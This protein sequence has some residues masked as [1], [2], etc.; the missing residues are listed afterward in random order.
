MADIVSQDFVNKYSIQYDAT[1]NATGIGEK[2]FGA[3]AATIAALG[4]N[5]FNSLVSIPE[6]IPFVGIHGIGVSN[7]S[8]IDMS[9]S[10]IDTY[11][12]LAGINDNWAN[13]YADNKD[14]V[15]TAA[16]I[17]GIIIPAGIALKGM[18]LLQ[19]GRL[20][21][22]A[23]AGL[24]DYSQLKRTSQYWEALQ[25][26]PKNKLLQD[27][28]RRKM[29]FVNVG[30]EA[31]L[32][33][34][35]EV[36]IL[37]TQNQSILMEDY[38]RDPGK[39]ILLG[40][41]G[42]GGAFGA[43]LATV[44]IALGQIAIRS[45]LA[46]GA[47]EIVERAIDD[48]RKLA[49]ATLP[50][51][52]S[53]ID[54]YQRM[55][56][57]ASEL[58][59]YA[60]NDDNI[61][62]HKELAASLA[63]VIEGKA[64]KLL[65]DNIHSPELKNWLDANRT[66]P[67]GIETMKVINGLINFSGTWGGNTI[68]RPTFDLKTLN[69]ATAK[70]FNSAVTIQERVDAATS[71]GFADEVLNAVGQKLGVR[72]IYMGLSTKPAYIASLTGGKINWHHIQ[73]PNISDQAYRV[74]YG[75]STNSVLA[76]ELGH[77][78]AQANNLNSE[79]TLQT[80]LALRKELE[81]LSKSFKPKI[82]DRGPLYAG[83]GRE[84]IADGVAIWMLVPSVRKKMPLFAAH[85]GE[86]VAYAQFDTLASNITRELRKLAMD[87]TSLAISKV[88]QASPNWGGM[89]STVI[90]D[91][92]KNTGLE[93]LTTYYSPLFKAYA[94]KEDITQVLR[95]VDI[96]FIKPQYIQSIGRLG[97]D[98]DLQ[99]LNRK[100]SPGFIDAHYINALHTVNTYRHNGEVFIPTDD[101][102][103]A[104]AWYSRLS[105]DLANGIPTKIKLTT[106]PTVVD[107]ISQSA[108]KSSSKEISLEELKQHIVTTK[109][110]YLAGLLKA[111]ASSQEMSIRL[112]LPMDNINAIIAQGKRIDEVGDIGTYV[113]PAHIQDAYMSQANRVLAI[114]SNARKL[115]SS[116]LRGP[117]NAA[118]F[119]TEA[120]QLAN[121]EIVDVVMSSSKSTLGQAIYKRILSDKDSWD[122]IKEAVGQISNE[123]VGA[124]MIN[125]ADFY[126]RRLGVAGERMAV[127]GQ[128]TTHT[129][130]ST[131][132]DI[133]A[134]SAAMLRAFK[135]TLAGREEFN[136]VI[137]ILNGTGGYRNID[138]NGKL[139]KTAMG[140]QGS[141]KE[142]I[143]ETDGRA[144]YISPEMQKI[145]TEF[146]SVSKEQLELHNTYNR[147]LGFKDMSDIGLHIP[148]FNPKNKF[149]SYILDRESTSPDQR[150]RLLVARDGK[151]LEAMEDHWQRT[152]GSNNKRFELIGSKSNQEDYNYWH[153]RVS[154]IEMD[155]A[156]VSKI[157][158]GAS[159][160]FFNPLGDDYAETIINNWHNR[161]IHYG[162]KLQQVYLSDL[163]E[164]L[165]NM[166]AVNKSYT[167]NQP[168][169]NRIAQLNQ[170]P[171]AALAVKNIILG[172]DQLDA[173]MTWKAVNNGVA[174]AMDYAIQ[175][176]AKPIEGFAQFISD[177]KY[178]TKQAF[179]GITN[180][181]TVG[182]AEVS[183][184][185]LSQELKSQGFR[186]PFEN[187]A[188]Y[189]AFKKDTTGSVTALWDI[190][191][192]KGTIRAPSQE[193]GERFIAQMDKLQIV[194][195]ARRLEVSP[196]K[197]EEYIQA[198][199]SFLTM[200]ALKV[201]EFG[202]AAVTAMSWPIMTLPNLYR[203]FTKTPISE[204]MGVVFPFRLIS[205]G[206]RFRHSAVG[207]SKM[208]QWTAEGYA[209]S[210]VSEVQEMQKLLNT[211]GKGAVARI[212]QITNSKLVERLSTATNFAEEETRLWS[213]STGYLA[214]K[215]AWPGISDREADMFAK[216]F[217]ARSVGNYNSGQ[218]PA[219]FQGV[220]GQ[221]IGLF[222]TYM[223]SW[224]QN[225]YRNIEEKSFNALMSQ[226][227]FQAGMFGMSSM[228][229]YNHY[230]TAIG[231][232]FSDKHFDLT[233]GTYRAVPEPIADFLIY[234]LPASLGVGL[235]TRGNI[236]PRVPFV[237]DKP[238]DTIA[239][240]NVIRQ[241]YGATT[242]MITGA[243]ASNG[244]ADKTRAIL[245][246]LSVQS[247][248]RPMARI[249]ELLPQYNQETGDVVPVGTVT[250][251]GNTVGTSD[252][253]WS[254]PGVLSRVFA[255][256]SSQ[257]AIKRDMLYLSSYYGSLDSDNRKEAA[258]LMKISL[259]NGTLNSDN[260]D[261][262]ASRYLR[263]GTAQGFRSALN[264]AVATT[265]GG[266]DATMAKKVRDGSPFM[267]MIDYAY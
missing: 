227:L 172:N 24:D 234:G 218:R 106:V 41:I 146:S 55:T 186:L 213:L 23:R 89:P 245:E 174:A 78:V 87:K 40:M 93:N 214:A 193:A 143:T 97:S 131:S 156:D 189:E 122:M 26:A 239:T 59:N 232:H 201:L 258:H 99:L 54:E 235:Y 195:T 79:L 210:I 103:V 127:L 42:G 204:T 236:Q 128:E 43:G 244:M 226:S 144:L 75:L 31:S 7:S 15:E 81:P 110:D 112:N 35:M 65:T 98:A 104:Q 119:D 171:D 249:V 101:I 177:G 179:T 182:K 8:G 36:A 181:P 262:I 241:L 85:I 163:M 176:V 198:G 77:A 205:D 45:S 139:Y 206:I 64:G 1:A 37:A 90:N 141:V 109:G 63:S 251:K 47:A 118:I 219:L 151:S 39:N 17:T 94:S 220:L 95:A 188:H 243:M 196:A 173:S 184:K 161:F 217:L 105:K 256:R 257:E 157:H 100:A 138:G 125:S 92:N 197:A 221:T 264:E 135:S 237:Q 10:T 113:N 102:A 33:L 216:S 231:E 61:P 82:W 222:Q 34:G 165:D 167:K 133:L 238:M 160:Q 178:L 266:I 16:F 145:L 115:M 67:D 21:M 247:M 84:L 27:S 207:A 69:T 114:S 38:I 6:F 48:T 76:H 202:H 194:E 190:S 215:K 80:Q 169:S 240:V 253:V 28:I 267:S 208:K 70:N 200:T 242:E 14:F 51:N 263:S 230:S 74:K 58:R 224:A 123:N 142:Y 108:I 66:T 166:S 53:Y 255:S 265:E 168:A 22:Y 18:R 149:I 121:S 185:R 68:A 117:D 46:K 150:I 162:K 129:L 72:P 57:K 137:N 159:G 191:I 32:A 158:S 140:E 180:I 147:L 107:G 183:Y 134:P 12:T 4:V 62:L 13:V 44:S 19:A 2:A 225:M 233:T 153:Q 148:A 86:A 49:G 50:V 116:K 187:F 228:P 83:L 223:L 9:K 124:I 259:R 203:D 30:Q 154:P 155:F 120:I 170:A 11:E 126:L 199:A 248:S 130:N 192:D 250:R 229:L 136:R 52:I 111:G 164:H 175:K 56:Y 5:T 25:Y 260:L 132:S 212:N 60:T 20:G 252:M 152:V 211:G 29:L 3:V 91:T 261:I 246:G 88:Y 73:M 71:V 254:I 209:G 96:G